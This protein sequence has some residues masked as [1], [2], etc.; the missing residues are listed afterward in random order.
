M[1]NDESNSAKLI[2]QRVLRPRQQVEERIRAAIFS[3]DLRSGERLPAEAELARQFEVSRTT[4]REALRS[5]TTQNLIDKVPGAGGGSFVRSIDHHS[6][7][8]L[9]QESLHNLLTLG[10]LG[11]EEVAMVRQYLE[12]PST[13]LAAEH[14][15]EEDLNELREIVEQQRTISVD[16]PNVPDLDERFHAAIARASGNRVLGSFV[17][18]LHRETEPVHYLDLSPSVGKTTVKQHQKIVKAIAERDP[19]AAEAAIVEH[20]GYL[21]KHLFPS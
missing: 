2:G 6:L 17:H 4:V 1:T 20:L 19:D 3:G 8:T 12:V 16:D 21:R 13:R 5:L 14:R 18:A 11:G 15:T 10:S 9:L 7:G